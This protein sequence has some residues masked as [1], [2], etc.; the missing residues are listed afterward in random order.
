MNNKMKI[1]VLLT[2]SILSLSIVCAQQQTS[3]QGDINV[4]YHGS[5]STIGQEYPI[6][7]EYGGETYYM[8]NETLE[9]LA[10]SNSD[11]EYLYMYD[12]NLNSPDAPIKGNDME[13]TR[14]CNDTDFIIDYETNQTVAGDSNANIITNVY[15]PDGSEMHAEETHDSFVSPYSL[16]TP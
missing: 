5:K 8:N 10:T 2:L 3:I 12:K 1:F 16:L 14:Q 6:S 9:K 15:N 7:F 13:F 11:F 4:T